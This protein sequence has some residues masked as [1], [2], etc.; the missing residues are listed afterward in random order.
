MTA[1]RVYYFIRNIL[2]NSKLTREK[3]VKNKINYNN[4]KRKNNNNSIII[5]RNI[6]TTNVEGDRSNYNFG[7][8]GGPKNFMTLLAIFLGVYVGSNR[9]GEKKN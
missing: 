3:F 9:F 8:G 5:K 6:S 1:N 2:Q 7:N 4:L